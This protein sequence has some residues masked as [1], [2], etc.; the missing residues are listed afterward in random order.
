MVISLFAAN[1]IIINVGIMI[2]MQ[3]NAFSMMIK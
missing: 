1:A 2:G 3:K